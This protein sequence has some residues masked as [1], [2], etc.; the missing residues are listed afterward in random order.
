MTIIVAAIGSSF[1]HPAEIG[2]IIIPTQYPIGELPKEFTK[3]SDKVFPL[4]LN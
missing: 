4:E 2:S 1:S 3:A